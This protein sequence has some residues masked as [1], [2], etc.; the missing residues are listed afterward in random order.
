M[1]EYM[2]RR[3]IKLDSKKYDKETSDSQNGV[4]FHLHM[5]PYDLP[6]AVRGAYSPELH[7][8]VIEFKYISAEPTQSQI[9]DR[10]VT[11]HVGE[12]SRRL[13]RIEVDVDSLQAEQV[14]LRL[15]S[16]VDRLSKGGLRKNLPEDNYDVVKDVIRDKSAQL[17]A[18]I[19]A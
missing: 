11:I 1:S 3:W 16:A 4:E 8:F 14:A 18:G 6:D 19:G 10:H 17:L 15:V 7:R 5:S 12:R 13:Y 9:V 2:F